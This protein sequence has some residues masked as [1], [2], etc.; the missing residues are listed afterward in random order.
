M[1]NFFGKK[2]KKKP[3]SPWMI[4]MAVTFLLVS[5]FVNGGKRLFQEAPAD[6]ANKGNSE[7]EKNEKP[8]AEP[9]IGSLLEPSKILNID[10]LKD[11]IL[12]RQS[13]AFHVS[14][15][16]IGEGQ[17]AICGQKVTINYQ[18]FTV[19]DKK[20]IASEKKVVFKIGEGSVLPALERGVI[21]MRNGGK[22]AVF[23]SSDMAYGVEQ[24]SRKDVPLLADVRFE[25]EL[26]DLSPDLPDYTAYRMLGDVS[27]RGIV[28]S[29]GSPVKLHVA[30]WSV[31]GKKLFDTKDKDNNSA[32]LAF[33]I[34]KSEVF[35][36]LEQGAL[37]MGAGMRRSLVVPPTM[38]KTMYNNPSIVDFSFPKN[39]TVIVDIESLP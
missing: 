35:L 21:G 32:P 36:G 17:F 13:I 15:N 12:P 28:Y 9:T 30:V 38:Q 37:G 5:F 19:E 3:N 11:R 4:W 14:D 39:Q 20:E 6:L 33:T 22:R 18:S 23:S 34:G 25:V 24:F 31:E 26:L 7:S 1:I 29:C 16:A 10:V 8:K 2:K 27:G